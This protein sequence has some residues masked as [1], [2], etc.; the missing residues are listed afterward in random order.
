MYDSENESYDRN[1]DEELD[2]KW[3]E[4]DILDYKKNYVKYKKIENIINSKTDNKFIL[5][6]ENYNENMGY[7]IEHYND[8]ICV[9][10]WVFI[11][12]GD[13]TKIEEKQI[14]YNSLEILYKDSKLF[15]KSDLI[16]YSLLHE[17]KYKMMY[18]F[19]KYYE[20]K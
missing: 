2:R 1:I 7:I 16:N 12:E 17:S 6:N 3:M 8:N 13:E 19:I 11:K 9:T 18:D 20:E 5:A 10:F 14:V 4:A 15:I